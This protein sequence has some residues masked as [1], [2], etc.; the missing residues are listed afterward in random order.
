MDIL[1]DTKLG[2]L[3]KEYSQQYGMNYEEMFSPIVKMTTIRTL[4][5]VTSIY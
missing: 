3:Q 5:V 4:N 1:N 2:H